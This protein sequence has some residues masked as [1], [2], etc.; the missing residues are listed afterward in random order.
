MAGRSPNRG[1]HIHRQ[2]K[3]AHSPLI[4]PNI[5]SNDGNATA[6]GRL[7]PPQVND[8]VLHFPPQ[9]PQEGI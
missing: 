4:C 1:F 7:A 9:T 6:R 3:A 5:Q 2:G 8:C